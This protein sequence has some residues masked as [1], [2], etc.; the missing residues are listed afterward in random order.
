MI[1]LDHNRSD[2]KDSDPEYKIETPLIHALLTPR[3]NT[4][5]M[6][7][8]VGPSLS[9]FSLSENR[10][11]EKTDKKQKLV[12]I[13]WNTIMNQRCTIRLQVLRRFYL[14]VGYLC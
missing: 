10:D 12:N 5:P 8:G 2:V 1:I 6:W 14:N 3:L 7:V 11:E 9:L 13:T 4:N